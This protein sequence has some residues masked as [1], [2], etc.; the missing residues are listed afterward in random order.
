MIEDAGAAHS[1]FA[2]RGT[3]REFAPIAFTNLLLT[4]VTLGIYRFWAKTRERQY[5]S[6]RTRFIDDTMEWTG[7]GLELFI[8]F[9]L[10]LIVFGLPLLALQFGI[11]ALAMRGQEG[12]AALLG[13]A[14]YLSFLFLFGVARFRAL[15]YRLSRTLWHGISGGSDDQGFEYGVQ[16]T[17]RPIV[18]GFAF[19]LLIPWSMVSLWNE[20]W[21]RMSFGPHE[22]TSTADSGPVL[23]RMLICVALAIP[24]LLVTG[25]LIG[26]T[27]AGVAQIAPETPLAILFALLPVF[28]LLVFIVFPITFYAVFFRECVSNMT[29]GH[30]EFQFDARTIDWV[31]L[32]LV[33]V[34][35]VIGT[36]GIGAIFLGYRHWS[37]FI[38]HLEAYGEVD[39]DSL[40][41]STTR[42]P[43]QGE[44]MLD[45]FDIGAI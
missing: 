28:Y 21:S 15:R 33:D 36:L 11:Q 4:I 9:V 1:A 41:G 32:Y 42:R 19:G 43:G 44:G 23:K 30:L 16:A 8:G 7:T 40:T 24:V 25:G 45:A 22:F 6:S 29:L 17:W 13:I 31:K 34:A 38:R 20:K 18:G 37:F 39:L 27:A 26:L 12:V 10:V 5:L 35:L 14:L 2:F 3:W